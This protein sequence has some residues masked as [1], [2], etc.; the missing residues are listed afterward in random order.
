MRR[1]YILERTIC[2]INFY[3]SLYMVN[4]CVPD[5]WQSLASQIEEETDCVALLPKVV[6]LIFVQVILFVDTLVCAKNKLSA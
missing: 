2:N 5:F 6:G 1:S 3:V 4:S